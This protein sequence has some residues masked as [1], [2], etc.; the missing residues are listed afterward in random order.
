MK[1][2]PPRPDSFLPLS[3]VVFEILVSLATA[4]RHGYSIM[5]DVRERTGEPLLPGSLYR[6]IARLVDSGLIEELDER[7]D[8][9]LDDERRR[10]YALTSL[11][12]A[13]AGAEAVRLERRLKSAR[14]AHLLP[15]RRP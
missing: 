1:T 8:P 14:S 2:P 3:T 7:P 9:E 12:R 13:V 11:G 6:A 10:Y 4:D 15:R 5:A